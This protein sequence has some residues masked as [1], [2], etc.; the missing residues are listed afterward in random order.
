[1]LSGHWP[2]IYII[3]ILDHILLIVH[4]FIF[5][6]IYLLKINMDDGFNIKVRTHVFSSYKPQQYFLEFAFMSY[7]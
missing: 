1:M 5:L 2:T 3:S 4:H 6:G 7:K